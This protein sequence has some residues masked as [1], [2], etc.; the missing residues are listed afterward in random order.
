MNVTAALFDLRPELDNVTLEKTKMLVAD[1]LA[2][3]RLARGTEFGRI[4]KV[5]GEDGGVF[6]IAALGHAIELDDMHR[7][8]ATHPGSAVV[9]AA[10]HTAAEAGRDGLALL[11]AVAFGVEITARVARALG[12]PTL[13]ERGYHP[14]SYC[15]AFGAAAAA[16][17]LRRL[18]R[19]Q[20]C[21]AMGLA[22]C[23]AAGLMC[24]V[25]DGPSSWYVQYGRGAAAG[26]DAARWAAAGIT[27]PHDVLGGK[28]G[29]LEVF[30][31]QSAIDEL[32]AEGVI[33]MAELSFKVH[34]CLFF[35]QAA[36]E[37]TLQ[38]LGG[39]RWDDVDR[40][41]LFLP[42]QASAVRDFSAYPRSRLAAQSDVRYLV[43]AALRYGRV[44]LAEFE[45]QAL[46]ELTGLWGSVSVSSLDSLSRLYP[47]Q[48]PAGVRI[49]LSDGRTL[50]AT[51]TTALGAPDRPLSWEQLQAKAGLP[52]D[53]LSLVRRLDEVKDLTP[54]LSV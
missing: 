4:L 17:R 19:S 33:G 51:V 29:L 18:T 45:Q 52:R 14:S 1:V 50:T 22:G 7:D 34:A 54:M 20:F 16:A 48:W 30:D 9:A 32:V 12:G 26:A 23:Q 36:V 42:E 31:G 24:G 11:Q 6:G 43:A 44:T 35:G 39:A 2:N 41:E 28:R 3:Q 46:G 53:V 10:L 15:A 25:E 21:H 37:A 38:A 27:A 47:A 13:Y 49:H 40:A 5:A 8:S